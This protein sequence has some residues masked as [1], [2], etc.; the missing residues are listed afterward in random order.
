MEEYKKIQDTASE[1]FYVNEDFER[2][3]LSTIY[4]LNYETIADMDAY[5]YFTQ[6][7]NMEK[8]SKE[9]QERIQEAANRLM[10]NMRNQYVNVQGMNGYVSFA[11]GVDK[12]FGADPNLGEALYGNREY[13]EEYY[14]SGVVIAYDARGV[15]AIRS[16]WNMEM[17]ETELQ[18]YLHAASMGRLLEDNGMDYGYEIVYEDDYEITTEAYT[19]EIPLED[20]VE[21]E[22][23]LTDG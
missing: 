23:V 7:Y 9:E 16:S 10:K 13:V 17:N 1:T 11:V 3:L 20:S 15:P 5:E 8:L 19:Y 18:M 21:Q 4:Y 2:Y 14:Q 12:N 6:G 22:R